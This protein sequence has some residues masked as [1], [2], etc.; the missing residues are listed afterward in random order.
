MF[1]NHEGRD[2][3]LSK[4]D[5]FDDLGFLEIDFS[6]WVENV[7]K[8]FN[9]NYPESIAL[10]WE[11]WHLFLFFFLVVSGFELGTLRLLGRCSSTWATPPTLSALVSF[12]IGPCIFALAGLDHNLLFTPSS[13]LGWLALATTPSIFG[14]HRVSL[15]F[16]PGRPWT[17]IFSIPASRVAGIT[18][19]SYCAWLALAS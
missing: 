12:Q 17:M 5:Y 15:P 1:W 10:T 19:G 4:K 16:P 7:I 2:F 3:Q 9:S 18:G 13:K 14:C 11:D 6:I 8:D